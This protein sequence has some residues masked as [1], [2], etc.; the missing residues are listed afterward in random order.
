MI[1]VELVQDDNGGVKKVVEIYFDEEGLAELQGRLDLIRDKKTDHVHL[2]SESWGLGDLN[3]ETHREN[4][5]IAHHLLF[6]LV[7]K[8]TV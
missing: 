8:D 2:M 6:S 5:Q 4:N 3:E 1:T 7:Q